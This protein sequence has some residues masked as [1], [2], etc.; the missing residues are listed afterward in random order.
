MIECVR[1]VCSGSGY[2]KITLFILPNKR[3]R[4]TQQHLAFVLDQNSLVEV[5]A[6]PPEFNQDN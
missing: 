2:V 5:K 6:L 3:E 1:A 4:E